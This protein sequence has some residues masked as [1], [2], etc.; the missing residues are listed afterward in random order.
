MDAEGVFIAAVIM[1][2][3]YSLIFFIM[4]WS[5]VTS[6]IEGKDGKLCV[7]MTVA[8]MM[9]VPAMW[10]IYTFVEWDNA[11]IIFWLIATFPLWFLPYGVY[12]LWQAA[13]GK[14]VCGQVCKCANCCKC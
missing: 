7:M 13:D 9:S 11:D 12:I 6:G 1:T 14:Q 2:V 8:I 10:C 4:C 3:V 5:A